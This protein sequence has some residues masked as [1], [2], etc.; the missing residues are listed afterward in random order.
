VREGAAALVDQAGDT[1]TVVA[2]AAGESGT[3]KS[4]RR[5]CSLINLHN[6]LQSSFSTTGR[7]TSLYHAVVGASRFAAAHV[8]GTLS[9]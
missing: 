6:F 9:Q 7:C 4:I 5:V 2:I 8:S 1:T 3:G